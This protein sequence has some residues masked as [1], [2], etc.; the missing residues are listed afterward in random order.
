MPPPWPPALLGS[1]GHFGSSPASL[2]PV[3]WGRR[4]RL[5]HHL[6][7]WP[8]VTGMEF[9]TGYRAEIL[10]FA[11]LLFGWYQRFLLDAACRRGGERRKRQEGAIRRLPPDPALWVLHAL[12]N[13]DLAFTVTDPGQQVGGR[14][15]SEEALALQDLDRFITFVGA[16]EE[17]E[18]EGEEEDA[19]ATEAGKCPKKQPPKKDSGAV[20]AAAWQGRLH[21]WPFALAQ[22]HPGQ[23]WVAGDLP[24]RGRLKEASFHLAC[25]P[26]S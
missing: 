16:G 8:P 20:A 9:V 22:P 3:G 5:P 4:G 23:G 10:D 25:L 2:R 21:R 1:S 15:Y 14:F 24:T 12:P 7:G 19:A 11:E 13:R 17:E 26:E 6:W 18:E